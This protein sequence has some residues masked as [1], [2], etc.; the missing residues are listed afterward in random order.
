MALFIGNINTNPI[1][2][3]KHRNYNGSQPTNIKAYGVSFSDMSTNTTATRLYTAAN[4]KFSFSDTMTKGADDFI[5]NEAGPFMIRECATGYNSSTGK[6]EVVAYKGDSNYSTYLGDKNYDIMIEFPVFYY[7]RPESLQFVVTSTP[8]VL[9]FVAS[10]MHNRNG[11]VYDYAYVSK[12]K[13]DNNFCSQYNTRP[14]TTNV[15]A[16]RDGVRQKG[17]QLMDY[18]THCM[19]TILM[20]IKYGD[21]Q[22]NTQIIGEH[23]SNYH[24]SG[25]SKYI[26][27]YD[28]SFILGESAPNVTLGLENYTSYPGV[29][30]DGAYSINGDLYVY[31]DLESFDYDYGFSRMGVKSGLSSTGNKL[32]DKDNNFINVSYGLGP[33]SSAVYA[34]YKS[35]IYVSSAQYALLSSS[36]IANDDDTNIFSTV[37]ISNNISG[38]SLIGL[39]GV[40]KRLSSRT[41]STIA[42]YSSPLSY[43]RVGHSSNSDYAKLAARSMF[44]R[45]AL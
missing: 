21:I 16:L 31:S 4:Y 5:A 28:G 13:L 20:F 43:G 37:T 38:V 12:F 39:I 14:Y 7:T 32:L 9:G 42:K 6:Q 36:D 10:P 8:G 3:T 1:I 18:P 40:G 24:L 17:M 44:W 34:P 45:N 30:L 35:L 23:P 25:I 19:L 15:K 11:K 29:W 27:S 2:D 41:H 22:F 26:R 33:V